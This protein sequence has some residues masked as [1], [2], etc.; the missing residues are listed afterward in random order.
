[1]GEPLGSLSGQNP[2]SE[3][4]FK[5]LATDV[6][7]DYMFASEWRDAISLDNISA[8]IKHVKIDEDVMG[9]LQ[10]T[11]GNEPSGLLPLHV[12]RVVLVNVAMEIGFVPAFVRQ[13]ALVF[14]DATIAAKRSKE[15][16]WKVEDDALENHDFVH[17]GSAQTERLVVLLYAVDDGHMIKVCYH[18][19]RASVALVFERSCYHLF[20]L[21]QR[22]S[23]CY[24]SA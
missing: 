14:N 7:Q 6:F 10:W 21:H 13:D 18:L 4:S 16:K 20:P 22:L 15:R 5:K 1:M 3:P 2:I 12:K 11:T 17:C 9:I 19:E 24:A 23:T 8:T